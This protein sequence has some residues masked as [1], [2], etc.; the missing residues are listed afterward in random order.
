M[1]APGFAFEILIEIGMNMRAVTWI[2]NWQEDHK[3]WLGWAKST[4]HGKA[5]ESNKNAVEFTA[6]NPVDI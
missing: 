6:M 5:T 4:E 2:E 3:Y 1:M